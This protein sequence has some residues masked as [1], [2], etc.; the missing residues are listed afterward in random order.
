MKHDTFDKY[1][2]NSSDLTKRTLLTAWGCLGAHR[3]DLVL[4]GG[5]AVRL[6]TNR[7]AGGLPDAVTLDVDFGINIGAAA[8]IYGS[9]RSTL[10]AHGFIE[11]GQRFVR[12]FAGMSLFIDLLTDDD[13]RETGSAVVDDSLSVAIMPGITRA[14]ERS[15][16]VEVSGT[17]LLGVTATERVLVA[18]V[19]PML[20]LKLNAFAS[21]KAPKDAHD[22]LYLA[23][24]YIGGVAG[25]IDEFALEKA[26]ANRG[27]G[28]ALR[29]LQDFFLDAS[30]QGPMACAAFRMNNEHLSPD[31]E[32]ESYALRQRCVTLAEALL[33]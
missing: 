12:K 8:G 20:V 19:G 15:R 10:S 18:E 14:L 22:V 33:A 32:E 28:R 11:E 4:V 26:A 17:T 27:M 1:P 30:G 3:E 31:R 2:L 5:L 16:T 6:L 24:K 23:E 13:I 7:A 25:A 21:R 9:I 29:C